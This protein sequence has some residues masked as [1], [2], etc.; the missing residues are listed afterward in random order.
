MQFGRTELSLM[1]WFSKS[2]ALLRGHGSRGWFLQWKGE[3]YEFRRHVWA[4][5]LV[6]TCQ[7]VKTSWK[8]VLS[9][10][11]DAARLGDLGK[12]VSGPKF[13]FIERNNSDFRFPGFRDFW[14]F[15]FYPSFSRWASCQGNRIT[16]AVRH[17][18][19]FL[20]IPIVFSLSDGY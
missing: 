16:G 10:P 9:I 17:R 6:E 15:R 19:A 20:L 3:R 12:R 11:K 1:P 14:I 13:P 5:F 2:G 18:E 4:V 7:K 8:W